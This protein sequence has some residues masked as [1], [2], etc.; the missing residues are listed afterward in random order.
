MYCK[1]PGVQI[2]LYPKIIFLI[3]NLFFYSMT[4]TLIRYFSEVRFRIFYIF[5]SF[6]LTFLACYYFSEQLLY[7]F[8]CPFLYIDTTMSRQFIFLEITEA[9]YISLKIAWV[10]S[11]YI[12]IPNI[13]YNFWSFLVPSRYFHERYNINMCARVYM[14]LFTTSFF[15]VHFYLIPIVWNFFINYDKYKNFVDI[16]LSIRVST[17]ILQ[18]IEM[19]F[20]HN[21]FLIIVCATILLIQT[22]KIH[23]VFL[24]SIRRFIFFVCVL[25]ASFV[26][27]PD[28]FSQL[29]FTFTFY[30]FFEITVLYSFFIYFYKNK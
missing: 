23:H 14:F 27:P 22:N 18:V 20:Y 13:I 28:I 17:Y 26:S 25:T 1:I 4:F 3:I 10:T 7:I 16:Q 21:I 15:F 29:F 11:T 12:L 24:A 19:F 8:I 5:L 9:F 6:L 2:P 30:F